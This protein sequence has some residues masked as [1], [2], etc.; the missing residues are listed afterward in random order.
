[1][2]RIARARNQWFRQLRR[3]FQDDLALTLPRDDR[4]RKSVT[5]S[6]LRDSR[7]SADVIDETQWSRIL[8][9]YISDMYHADPNS[10]MP[11]H[12]VRSANIYVLYL[13]YVLVDSGIQLLQG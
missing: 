2:R 5:P 13:Y 10:T 7:T 11:V 8:E 1:M 3:G 9:E 6:S 12:R 4:S